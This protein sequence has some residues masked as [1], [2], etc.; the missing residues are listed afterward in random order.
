M[1]CVNRSHPDFIR[2]VKLTGGSES[3]V[4]LAVAMWQEH[5][6]TN[7]FPSSSQVISMLRNRQT[8]GGMD[9]YLKSISNPVLKADLDVAIKNLPARVDNVLSALKAILPDIQVVLHDSQD[10]FTDEVKKATGSEKNRAGSG[11]YYNNEIHLNVP[12]ML[13]MMSKNN[14]AALNTTEHEGVHPILETIEMINPGSVASLFESL[15][16]IEKD[17]GL[18]GKY[19]VKFASRYPDSQ[20]KEEAIT[21]FIADIASGNLDVKK[22]DTSSAMRIKRFLVDLFKSLGIDLSNL[23]NKKDKLISLAKDIKSAFDSGKGLERVV[24]GTEYIKYKDIPRMQIEN[25]GTDGEKDLYLQK[26]LDYAR[27]IIKGNRTLERLGEKEERARISGGQRNV[28]ASAIAGTGKETSRGDQEGYDERQR[29]EERLIQ[30]AKQEGIWVD[31]YRSIFGDFLDKGGESIVYY[32]GDI[33]TKINDFSFH[34]EPIQFFDRITIHNLLFPESPY[35]VIGFTFREDT[36]SFS[37]I[38]QQPFINRKR[39]ATKQEIDNYMRNLGYTS[40]GGNG[41]I[42]ENYIVEDLHSGNV[43][44]SPQGKLVFIDP[45]IHINTADEGYGG[46]RIVNDIVPFSSDINDLRFQ[47]NDDLQNAAI[48]GDYIALTNKS[49]S[50]TSE[51]NKY[52]FFSYDHGERKK[53]G[54]KRNIDLLNAGWPEWVV[55]IRK[56]KVYPV[57]ENPKNYKNDNI[58]GIKESAGS[59]GMEAIVWNVENGTVANIISKIDPVKTNN[60]RI[61]FK[62][63]E[64]AKITYSDD[65]ESLSN[66][67]Y[68]ISDGKTKKILSANKDGMVIN[69]K[70]QD[71]SSGELLHTRLST[72]SGKSK[73]IHINNKIKFSLDENDNSDNTKTELQES[74]AFGRLVSDIAEKIKEGVTDIKELKEAAG[75]SSDNIEIWSDAYDI[76]MIRAGHEASNIRQSALSDIISQLPEGENRPTAQEFYRKNKAL[77]DGLMVNLKMIK[78][79][80]PDESIIHD[81]DINQTWKRIL[82]VTNDVGSYVSKTLHIS[83]KFNIDDSEGLLTGYWDQAATGFSDML[84]YVNAAIED[85]PSNKQKLT[86]NVKEAIK[87][88]SDN[89]MLR[90]LEVAIAASGET[91][92]SDLAKVVRAGS[93]AGRVLNVIKRYINNDNFGKIKSD[94]AAA[95]MIGEND[96][97]LENIKLNENNS[98]N[99]LSLSDEILTIL[100]VEGMTPDERKEF[101]KQN[102]ELIEGIKDWLAKLKLIPIRRDYNPTNAE[103]RVARRK[104]TTGVSLLKDILSKQN[105]SRIK[106]QTE[107]FGL[108]AIKSIRQ[109]VRGVINIYGTD[110]K[111]IILELQKVFDDNGILLDSEEIVTIP[112]IKKFIYNAERYRI[113]A[114]VIESMAA[115]DDILTKSIIDMVLKKINVPASTGTKKERLIDAMD[116][117]EITSEVVDQVRKEI[118]KIEDAD[119][120]EKMLARLENKFTQ[121]AEGAV[122]DSVLKDSVEDNLGK[123]TKE[124]VESYIVDPT[125]TIDSLMLSVM[126]KIEM[127]KEQAEV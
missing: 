37:V 74:I 92:I 51:G 108:E 103:V 3:E 48:N 99:A 23:I 67:D 71:E 13:Q 83:K 4:E 97:L 45:I 116:R 40:I 80:L 76:A 1:N 60:H 16:K 62:I 69:L 9:Q 53:Y 6:A 120:R 81:V 63:P 22:L 87:K 94:L 15:V 125:R 121:I 59:D 68:Y 49:D 25:D 123:I 118:N 127:T 90:L 39:K 124:I 91:T 14:L 10:T 54:T 29:Q 11:F 79:I 52:V 106:Q 122:K 2:L 12:K 113:R 101:F 72:F 105:P 110:Q 73:T 109:I 64:G 55:K 75:V 65:I 28:E 17:L 82:K 46:T 98:E 77:L 86:D 5:N 27:K 93:N 57:E 61:N 30:Y 44:F 88:D 66:A 38:V 21:E 70:W 33:V 111:T 102:N 104:I 41:Y 42:N 43:F 47:L 56:S 31:D 85:D 112:E 126:D 58:E 26:V 18:D 8:F 96:T 32:D 35:K 114:A 7:G 95:T 34:D 100:K 115:K 107:D 119:N 117:G 78:Q 89:D 20:K 36:D 24:N 84:S 50:M 19:S